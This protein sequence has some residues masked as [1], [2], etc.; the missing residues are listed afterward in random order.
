VYTDHSLFIKNKNK[1]KYLFSGVFLLGFHPNRA[2]SFALS[3]VAKEEEQQ[4]YL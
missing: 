1:I 2:S 4:E 3:H